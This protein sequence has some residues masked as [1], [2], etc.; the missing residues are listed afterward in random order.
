MFSSYPYL[1]ANILSVILIAVASKKL[2]SPQQNTL[3]FLGGLTSL[4][5]FPFTF[6]FEGGYWAPVRLGGWA[7]GIEDALCA[8]ALGA[9]SWFATALFFGPV[10]RDAISFL[11]IFKRYSAVA[12]GSGIVFFTFYF[13]GVDI[14]SAYLLMCLI[15]GLVLFIRLRPLRKLALAGLW[16]FPIL[17]LAIVKMYFLIWP[18]FVWQW[19]TSAPWGRLYFGLPLGEIAWAFGFAFYWPLF[20][21]HV[22]K[23]KIAS[24]NRL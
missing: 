11:E 15:V 13:L 18:N 16:K 7:L 8:Y 1:F 3:V 22:F 24:P 5:C 23:L 10:S 17:Y 9:M 6:L 4:L 12:G 14:M 2:L 21:G 19:N 20:M